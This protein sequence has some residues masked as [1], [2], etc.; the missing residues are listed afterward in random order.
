MSQHDHSYKHLFSHKEM[1]ADLLT[2]FVD[3]PWVQELD[4]NT[5]EKLNASYVTDDLRERADDVVWRVRFRDHWLYVYLLIDVDKYMAVRLLTYVGLLYQD[6]IKSR[7]LPADG[8][9]PP[10]F[11]VVLYNGSKPWHAAHALSDLIQPVPDTLQ[12]YQP[13][14]RYLLINEREYADDEL[15]ALH[16]LVATLF[17]L[18]NSATVQH[19]ARLVGNLVTWLAAPEQQSLNRAFTVW[20]NRVLLPAKAVGQPIANVEN[21]FEVRT[22]LAERVLEWTKEWKEQGLQQGRQEGLQMGEV[23]VLKRLLAKRFG[24][25]PAWAITTL[26]SATPSQLESWAERLLDAD[27]LEAFFSA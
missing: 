20:L 11:P 12:P 19:I 10:V 2:G 9:L 24:E 3:Q 16:N 1:V 17:Q 4:L 8:M 26:D 7:Q 21:L 14:L 13:N 5:L 18:E 6:L 22:M 23:V 15:A 27:T 25:L